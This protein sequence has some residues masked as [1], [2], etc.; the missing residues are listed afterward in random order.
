MGIDLADVVPAGSDGRITE[1]DLKRYQAGEGR[2]TTQRAN[3]RA[4]EGVSAREEDCRGAWRGPCGC[5][6]IEIVRA[7]CARGRGRCTGIEKS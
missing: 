4:C 3:G 6:G 5:E 2:D 7:H 1:E